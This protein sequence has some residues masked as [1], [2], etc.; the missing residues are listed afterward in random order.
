MRV[1]KWLSFVDYPN[2]FFVY[3]EGTEDYA[4]NLW[5]HCLS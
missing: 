2:R 3:M 1:V 4:K 5:K